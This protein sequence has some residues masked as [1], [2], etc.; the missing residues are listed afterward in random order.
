[1]KF[2]APEPPVV[3]SGGVPAHQPPPLQFVGSNESAVQKESIQMKGSPQL[4]SRQR[5]SPQSP[6]RRRRSS[7]SPSRQTHSSSLQPRSTP[8]EAHNRGKGRTSISSTRS[9]SVETNMIINHP[10][11]TDNGGDGRPSS[12]SLSMSSHREAHVES[13][14]GASSDVEASEKRVEPLHVSDMA[15]KTWRS[16]A[17]RWVTKVG[18]K[19]NSAGDVGGCVDGNDNDTSLPSSPLRSASKAGDG[20][21]FPP[22]E[23]SVAFSLF[24]VSLAFDCLFGAILNCIVCAVI[25]MGQSSI[26]GDDMISSLLWETFTMSFMKDDGEGSAFSAFVPGGGFVNGLNFGEGGDKLVL[27]CVAISFLFSVLHIGVSSV[28][29][30]GILLVDH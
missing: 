28:I 20:T 26:R 17:S 7:K 22:A 3:Y 24:V 1:M 30:L 12:S 16:Q 23:A 5:G 9:T 13:H 27:V 29:L 18:R 6:S 4:P 25:L 11:K 14:G 2:D 8:L 10:N 19:K 21:G 15:K